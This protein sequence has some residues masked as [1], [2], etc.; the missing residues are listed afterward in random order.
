MPANPPPDLQPSPWY[1]YGGAVLSTFIVAVA[2]VY[3]VGR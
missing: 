1:D 3:F 2:I